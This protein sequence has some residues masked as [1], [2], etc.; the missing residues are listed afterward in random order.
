MASSITV[1]R[2]AGYADRLREY[3]ILVDDVEIGRIGNGGTCNFPLDPGH[4]RIRLK[5]DWC[6]SQ[7][8]S[9]ELPTDASAS[10]RCGSSLRGAK[11]WFALFY[12]LF[13]REQYLWVSRDGT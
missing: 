9:F 7:Q 13:R 2:D 1:V 8:L 12:V 6:G 11:M 4:H 10:F 5:I 3:V